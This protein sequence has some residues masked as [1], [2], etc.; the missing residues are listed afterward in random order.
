MLSNTKL[1]GF[2]GTHEQTEGTAGAAGGASLS[3]Q[4]TLSSFVVTGMGH[5][6]PLRQ[7]RSPP[8]LTG[9]LSAH[10][11]QIDHGHASS[12][13]FTAADVRADNTGMHQIAWKRYAGHAD[14]VLYMQTLYCTC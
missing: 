2:S 5:V 13:V 12:R 4:E 9:T 1:L 6:S 7:A 10:A 11:M 3:G 8:H 14:T